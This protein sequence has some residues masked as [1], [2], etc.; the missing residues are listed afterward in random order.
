MSGKRTLGNAL[1][2]LGVVV[3]LAGLAM[4]GTRTETARTCYD[5]AMQYGQNCVETS[6]QAPTAKG[7]VLG[8]GF[9]SLVAGAVLRRFGR[10]AGPGSGAA[11]RPDGETAVP[12]EQTQARP[13][14]GGP[15][16]AETLAERVAQHNG[17]GESASESERPGVGE[18]AGATEPG[19]RPA[20][21]TETAD[22]TTDAT[23]V[24]DRTAPTDASPAS[25][26]SRPAESRGVRSSLAVAGRSAAVAVVGGLVATSA[27]G[28][29]VGTAPA[30]VAWLVYVASGLSAVALWRRR[31]ADSTD[32]ARPGAEQ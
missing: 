9:A 1:A 26:E 29:L 22:R 24:T 11:G 6:Y 16:G 2:A 15:G 32:G 18:A 17:D 23:G 28:L 14:T 31:G 3:L 25:A 27:A 21:T 4:P 19:E 5:S 20:G 30:G 12:G 13:R 8:T 7:P 10:D